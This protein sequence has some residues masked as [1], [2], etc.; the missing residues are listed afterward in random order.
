MVRELQ[1]QPPSAPPPGDKPPEAR[2]GLLWR[3]LA[4]AVILAA[5][6][7]VAHYLRHPARFGGAEGRAGAD[8]AKGEDPFSPVP[9]AEGA[10]RAEE[11]RKQALADLRAHMAGIV[12]H[13]ADEEGPY[14]DPANQDAESRRQFLAGVFGLPADYPRNKVPEDLAPKDARVLAVFEN[15]EGNGARMAILRVPGDIHQALSAVHNQYVAAGWK[16]PE[17]ADPSAQTD[18]G[19]LMRFTKGR[20]ERI[21]YARPRQSGGET[22]VAVYDEPH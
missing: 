3:I 9:G 12:M 11:G 15:P 16:A 7:A 19:W 20:S 6:L 5:M 14:N 8:A 2:G 1:N 18:Q 21:V 13:A 17:Q 22:L 10:A 4:V